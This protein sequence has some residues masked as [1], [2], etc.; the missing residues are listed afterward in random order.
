MGSAKGHSPLLPNELRLLSAEQTLSEEVSA[1]SIPETPIEKLV[2][3]LR[4]ENPQAAVRFL[5]SNPGILGQDR[6]LPALDQHLQ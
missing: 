6:L 5:Q 3:R 2:A 1:S 4:F